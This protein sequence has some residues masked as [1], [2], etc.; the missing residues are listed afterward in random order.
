MGAQLCNSPGHIKEDIHAQR[1]DGSY[2]SHQ[3]VE[4][5]R[6]G[7][8]SYPDPLPVLTS[9]PASRGSS[10]AAK[11][12]ANPQYDH[13]SQS[14]S[15]HTS[16]PTSPLGGF[17]GKD[18]EWDPEE[19]LKKLYEARATGNQNLAKRVLVKVSE[20]NYNLRN[21][22]RVPKTVPVTY[23]KCRTTRVRG[24]GKDPEV[25]FSNMYTCDAIVAL[26]KASRRLCALNFANGEHVGGGYKHGAT[27]QEEDLCR[28][29]PSLYTTLYNAS[30]AGHYPFGPCTC[31]SAKQPGKYSDVLYTQDLVVARA[32]EERGY[33]LLPASGQVTVSLVTAAAPNVNFAKEIYDLDLMYNTIQSIFVAPLL[34]D[35]TVNTII[36]GAWGCGA[37]GGQPEDV[38]SLFARA[39][40]D[41]GRLYDEIHFAIPEGRNADIFRKTLQKSGIRIP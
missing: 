30:K 21:K 8:S 6:P 20:S 31:K 23:E 32:S 24:K 15:S 39:I 3:I 29:I 40:K 7:S 19:F 18:G 33:A 17:T 9:S 26:A 12:P 28:R 35:P 2:K 10:T 1:K 16:Q 4:D 14:T 13:N 38:S 5:G 34:E 27:A 41:F 11:P 25:S 22:W 37:F 36:V